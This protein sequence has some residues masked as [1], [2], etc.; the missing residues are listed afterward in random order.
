MQVS[1]KKFLKTKARRQKKLLSENPGW[2]LTALSGLCLWV[3]LVAQQKR[4][5]V[6]NPCTQSNTPTHRQVQ[7]IG[8]TD[9]L[10]ICVRADLNL[11]LINL[12]SIEIPGKYH[13]ES[14]GT[15]SFSCLLHMVL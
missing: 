8:R 12:P 7:Y 13:V 5:A 6:A 10:V 11:F 3:P 15:T 1:S 4:K 14:N 9:M 2:K